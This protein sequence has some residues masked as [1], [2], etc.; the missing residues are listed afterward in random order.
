MDR[1]KKLRGKFLVLTLSFMMICSIVQIPVKA[2]G[3]DIDVMFDADT[4]IEIEAG[5]S[6][7]I[8]ITF[9]K[10][11]Y[12]IYTLSNY[13]NS[14]GFDQ[15]NVN[16]CIFTVT[17]EVEATGTYNFAITLK[18]TGQTPLT[19]KQKIKIKNATNDITVTTDGNGTASANVSKAT[20]GDKVTVTA[21]PNT[22]YK[23]K[24]WQSDE[25]V[26][27]AN[28]F[29]MPNKAVT[30]KAI[31]E[32]V[33]VERTATIG[34]VEIKGVEG[35]AVDKDI[36]VTLTNDE[37]NIGNMDI[38]QKP[39]SNFPNGISLGYGS[40]SSNQTFKISVFGTPTV[41]GNGTLEL[42][43]P[44]EW[45]K[46]GKDLKVTA[47]PNAKYDFAKIKITA[48][49]G[50]THKTGVNE[51]MTFTCNGGL[52]NLT[53]IYVDGAL[54]DPSNYT[55][56]SGST[57]L[58]LKASYLNTLAVGTHTLKFQY[59]NDMSADTSFDVVKVEDEKKPPVNNPVDKND[60]PI[61]D[62]GKINASQTGDA[63]NI[64]FLM[65]MLVLFGGLVI[66]KRKTAKKAS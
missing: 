4:A 24:E 14:T 59:K 40:S 62:T 34:N 16:Y 37:L 43:I 38:S 52:D 47:N 19:V 35:E 31:F 9:D 49:A 44:G 15:K 61:K 50:S 32:A 58:T 64:A 12:N 39:T 66:K 20:K 25:V 23:F 57:I 48:G 5:K 10:T 13:W 11:Y 65:S 1:I 22:G 17:P 3:A 46:S 56:K 26:V 53:G 51:N 45:L 36:T 29:Y 33:T 60:T 6:T 2:A 63:T 8:K 42:T 30:V 54:L 28:Y 55:V 18:D 21:T 27:A 7:T 41:T